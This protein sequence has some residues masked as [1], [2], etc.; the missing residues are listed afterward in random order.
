MARR[1]SKLPRNLLLLAVGGAAAWAAWIW[2]PADLVARLHGTPPPASGAVVLDACALAPE[3]VLAE[4]VGRAAVEAR[5]VQPARDVPAASACHWEFFGGAV[6]GRVFTAESLRGAGIGM[7]LVEYFRSAVT[8]LEYE[9]KQA[10]GTVSGLGDE[11]FAAGFDGAPVS[12][13]IARRGG[14][15]ITLE[16]RGIDRRTAETFARALLARA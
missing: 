11:A 9:Y 2:L 10:P 12:Q 7:G 3:Q 1:R 8:G 13:L 14:M 6:D 15:M 16:A 5:R 4:M